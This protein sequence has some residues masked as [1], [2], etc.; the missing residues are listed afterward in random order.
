MCNKISKVQNLNET[1]FVNEV[2]TQLREKPLRGSQ[3]QEI[4]YLEDKASTKTVTLTYLMQRSYLALWHVTQRERLP[5][6]LPT[7]NCLQWI[8]LP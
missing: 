7:W 2:K 6:K 8:P 1:Y 5:T 4:H 3:T